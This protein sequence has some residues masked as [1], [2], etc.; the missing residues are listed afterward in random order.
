MNKTVAVP[1]LVTFHSQER[2]WSTHIHKA[3]KDIIASYYFLGK[4]WPK[5]RE[6][7]IQNKEILWDSMVK[8]LFEKV[9]LRWY[10]RWK[11][12]SMQR[13][14]EILFLAE[15]IACEK[16][17]G[18]SSLVQNCNKTRYPSYSEKGR[19]WTKMSLEHRQRL[20]H[21]DFLFHGLEVSLFK[22]SRKPLEKKNE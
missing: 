2:E 1:V 14:G 5:C 15:G 21:E 17:L 12:H 13:V 19:R 22:S 20:N 7:V 9:S 11:G 18:K 6:K 10:F 8:N 16:I 3:F 4:K